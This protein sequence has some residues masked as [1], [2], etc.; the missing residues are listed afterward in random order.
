M[1]LPQGM[2]SPKAKHKLRTISDLVRH[3]GINESFL[4]ELLDELNSDDTKLYRSW[5]EPKKSGGTRPIDAPKEKL[6][7]VQG[8][9]ND[10]ILQRTRI[11]TAAIGGVRGK[12]LIDNLKMHVGKPMVANFDLKSFFTNINSRQVFET[13]CAIGVSPKV[14]KVLTR[15]TTFKGRIPQGAPTSTM[16]ANIVAGYERQNCL[17]GRIGGLCQKHGSQNKRWIDDLSISGPRYL[18]RFK[19]TVEKIIEQSGFKPNIDK[20]SFASDREPQVVT[21]HL[22]NVKPNVMKDERRNLRA[23]LHKCRTL[24]PEK[25]AEG[26]IVKLRNRLRGKIAHF[27][28]VNPVLGPKFLKDFNSIHWPTPL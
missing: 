27:Q 4:C 8:C 3:L 11:H 21:G 23:I 14:A 6:S 28:S 25:V 18:P 24:G 5:E 2:K 20:I 16:L 17:D 12:G 10:R 9:I 19:G 26:S 22:V 15:L 13:F 7:F 1:A